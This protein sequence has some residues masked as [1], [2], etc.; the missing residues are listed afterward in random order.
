MSENAEGGTPPV[1]TP[2]TTQQQGESGAPKPKMLTEEEAKELAD[3]KL[4]GVLKE[5]EKVK[6]RLAEFEAEEEKKK[7]AELS[8]DER[9]AKAEAAAAEAAQ[10]LQAKEAAEAAEIAE[11][12]EEN[13][14]A[15][16]ALKKDR[17]ELADLIPVGL[18]P[19]PLAKWLSKVSSKLS[20]KT[21]DVHGGGGRG[22]P[23]PSDEDKKKAHADEIQKR[24]REFV[25]G[26]SKKDK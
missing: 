24:A 13:K 21:I 20:I 11:I 19:K 2:P 1:G 26:P 9:L 18:A 3:R 5:H 12:E 7:Q 23:P 14:E 16:K 17:P 6:A 22:T 4:R 15:I 25:L 10:K 8:K